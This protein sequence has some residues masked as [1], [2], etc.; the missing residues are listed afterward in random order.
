MLHLEFQLTTSDLIDGYY[1]QIHYAMQEYN[2]AKQAEIQ[3]QEAIAYTRILV[4][5][6]LGAV[7]IILMIYWFHW[8]V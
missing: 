1:E 2:E 3:N 4:V 6:L 5:C 8:R 7:I